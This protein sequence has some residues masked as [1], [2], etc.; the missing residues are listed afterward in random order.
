MFCGNLKYRY[1]HL[2][3]AISSSIPN[4]QNCLHFVVAQGASETWSENVQTKAGI[5]FIFGVANAT[6][7]VCARWSSIEIPFWTPNPHT[8]YLFLYL[9][10]SKKDQIR[11]SKKADTMDSDVNDHDEH[12]LRLLK[13]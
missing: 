2:L 8:V 1:V 13:K 12:F 9:Q 5:K 7:R 3:V 6:V 11:S 10:H 4:L